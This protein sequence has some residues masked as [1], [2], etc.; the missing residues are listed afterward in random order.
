MAQTHQHQ[1][2]SDKEFTLLDNAVINLIVEKTKL[3]KEH[4]ST[5]LP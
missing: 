5:N 4:L 2:S 1:S 3:N